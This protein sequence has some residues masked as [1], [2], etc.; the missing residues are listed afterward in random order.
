VGCFQGKVV[1][2]RF[3]ARLFP[4]DITAARGRDEPQQVEPAAYTGP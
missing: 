1:V 4:T 2:E 3:R